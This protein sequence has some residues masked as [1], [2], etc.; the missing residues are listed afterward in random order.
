MWSRFSLVG[1]CFS[2]GSRLGF[3]VRGPKWRGFVLRYDIACY[4]TD[5]V[6]RIGKRKCNML[7]VSYHKSVA[8]L[9]QAFACYL[10]LPKPAL[11]SGVVLTFLC[12]SCNSA[13]ANSVT[14]LLERSA[15]AYATRTRC[16]ETG[17]ACAAEG[18]GSTIEVVFPRT[19]AQAFLGSIMQR[20]VC[21]FVLLHWK[22]RHAKQVG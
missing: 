3:L 16:M 9:A 1:S 19:R 2:F 7:Y 21:D 11:P 4:M 14:G 8:I 12:C 20:H 13:M 15:A 17:K 6:G 18:I 5:L 22:S 10:L